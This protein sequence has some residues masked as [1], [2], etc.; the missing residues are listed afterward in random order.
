[1][2]EPIFRKL[3]Y[4][5]PVL[6]I[7][8]PC[9]IISKCLVSSINHVKS[10]INIDRKLSISL[11]DSIFSNCK[12]EEIGAVSLANPSE[13]FFQNNC[14]INNFGNNVNH[15]IISQ[16]QATTNSYN[17]FTNCYSSKYDAIFISHGPNS[18]NNFSSQSTLIFQGNNQYLYINSSSDVTAN[19]LKETPQF[20]NT[21]MLCT[22]FVVNRTVVIKNS[23]LDCDFLVRQGNMLLIESIIKSYIYETNISFVDCSF[24][25]SVPIIQFENFVKCSNI[26]DSPDT[27]VFKNQRNL[28]TGTRDM[29]S[30][31]LQDSEFMD[32]DSGGDGG[33]AIFRFIT[34]QIVI[35]HCS[36]VKCRAE[37]Y[38]GSILA[39]ESMAFTFKNSCCNQLN[40]W[41]GVALYLE[42][43]SSN[44]S[45]SSC[46]FVMC[47]G[48]TIN[49]N[50]CIISSIRGNQTNLYKINISNSYGYGSSFVTISNEVLNANYLTV[51]HSICRHNALEVKRMTGENLKIVNNTIMKNTVMKSCLIYSDVFS[52]N[53][54]RVITN[55]IVLQTN[56]TETVNLDYGFFTY[57]YFCTFDT[58]VQNLNYN[59]INSTVIDYNPD[60][61]LI[62]NKPEYCY[63][64]PSKTNVGLIVGSVMG[65]VG[66]ILII[67]LFIGLYHYIMSK[68]DVQRQIVSS[69]VINDF[70]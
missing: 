4:Y 24:T 14:F 9:I 17:F 6:N 29:M 16:P 65:S 37:R 54:Y 21:Y 15:V 8:I 36:F 64:A 59:V 49:S 57:F 70:G 68:K 41:R 55:S 30:I 58:L 22:N 7:D 56:L 35:D 5:P 38:G 62:I 39:N 10:C 26:S 33:A 43:S 32:L 52:A 48:E 20:M 50:R 53:H 60:Y 66:L 27:T 11:Q 44:E 1:M 31:I 13:L 28:V 19:G 69:M 46:S 47:S 25:E 67:A 40:A 45:I 3:F 12:S 42:M 63:H 2:S 18:K 34:K 61:Q 51:C 23:H